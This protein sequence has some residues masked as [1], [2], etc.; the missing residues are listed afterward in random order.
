MRRKLK[1]LT[2]LLLTAALL[3]PSGSLAFAVE[4]GAG[5]P[6]APVTVYQETFQNGKGIAVQSGGPTLTVVQDKGF[7]GNED[8]YA[9]HVDNRKDNW[10]GVDLSY[11]DLGLKD[12]STYTVRITLFVD[13]GVTVPEEAKADVITAKETYTTFA[14]GLF[15]AGQPLSLNG[16]FTADS[17]SGD[18]AIRIQS[19]DIGKAVPFYIGEILITGE[20]AS[21]G[22]GI[23]RPPAMP[24]APVTFE[25]GLGGFTG[26][27]STET[28]TVT[29]EANHT[30]GGSFALKIE[31]RTN[32]WHGPN[33][34]LNPYIDQG[35]EYQ[36]SA[37][38]KLISPS[39]AQLQLST[40]V[41]DGNGAS[42]ISLQQK[43]IREEDGWVKLEGSYR[44]TNMSGNFATLYI[45][46]PNSADASFYID[47]VRFEPTG[48]GPIVIEEGLTPV[49][50]VYESDFLVGTAIS[51]EDLDGVRLQLMNK[52]FNAVTAGNAMKP[53][54]LQR[55]EDVFTFEAADAMVD[56]ALAEGHKVHGHVLVWHQ[57][58]PDWMNIGK[59]E[60]GNDVPLSREEA[61]DHLQKHI[62][63]VV[64]HFGDRVISWDVVNEAMNDNPANPEDWEN[65]LRRSPWFQAIGPD[66]VEQ[67]FLAAR[68]ALDDRQLNDVKLYYNDYNED[69]QNKATAIYHMVKEINE[70]Y[71]QEH[72]GTLLIDGLGM[73]GHYNLNTNPENVKLTLERFLSLGV[74]V[75]ITELDI[76]AG[77]NRQQ[78][79]KEAGSQAYLYAVLM[80]LFKNYAENIERVTFWGLDDGTSWRAENS[81]LPFD[82]RLQAKKAYYAI[83]D[84]EAYMEDYSP[85]SP[86]ALRGNA[87]YGT[88][89]LD[90]EADDLWSH[91]PELPINRFQSAWQGA[92]GSARVLWDED[93]LYVLVRV[94]DTQLD[95]TNEQEWQQDS[96]EIFVDENNGKTTFYQQDDGQYRVNFENERS[97]GGSTDPE[98]FLS[99]VKVSG[100]SYTL[101]AKI[102]FKTV[103]PAIDA[104]IGFDVQI[105]DAKDGSRQSVAAWNDTTGMGY[106]DPSVF[107]IVTLRDEGWTEP[108]PSPSPSPSP[109][110]T[111]TPG[112]TPSPSPNPN[113]NPGL[114]T[115]SNPGQPTGS[116]TPPA[117][118]ETAD[119]LV[120]L[121]PATT[122]VDGLSR[123]TV[124]AAELAQALQQA[125]APASGS[126]RIAVAVPPSEAGSYE[127]GIPAASLNGPQ[128]FEL[129]VRTEE[130]ALLLPAGLLADRKDTEGEVTVRIARVPA[131]QVPASLQRLNASVIRVELA[132]G[133]QAIGLK[134][135][136]VPATLYLP[137]KP[138]AAEARRTHT[139]VGFQLGAE[140]HPV[141]VI[142]SR[143][144]AA[145][146]AVSLQPSQWGLFAG[147]DGLKPYTDTGSV[148]WA[149]EAIEAMTARGLLDGTSTAASGRF[150]PSTPVTRGEFTALLVELLELK[151]SSGSAESFR[152]VPANAPYR[153]G[154]NIARELGIAGGYGDNSFRPEV[155]LSRQDMMSLTARALAAAGW[156]LTGDSLEGYADA[157]DLS[158]YARDSASALIGAG[159]VAGKAGKIAPAESLSRAEAAVI[160]HRIWSR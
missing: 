62:D 106:T 154:L 153:A 94:N 140:G 145:A 19:N 17:A 74:T 14:G 70:R 73:Q 47:D 148:S 72:P 63:T 48:T 147:A 39:S 99:A 71:A 49:K 16:T 24:F 79:E 133:G 135:A 144:D 151:P 82:S 59:D 64:K 108:E 28:L 65:A 83:I 111:P 33:I 57:Q 98:G 95:K 36:L 81:P 86:D 21:P 120:T 139:R 107:G 29:E 7:A 44:Y 45:E 53:D 138:S 30:E 50:D 35:Q 159:I 115:G 103:T 116:A 1:T 11:S 2:S 128:P 109:T 69:N 9:L 112:P 15:E 160:L 127:L 118:I 3:L 6:E 13:E 134:D 68:K 46:S 88:P 78:T 22:G 55:T 77:S 129:L 104:K 93:Y 43:N 125:A 4:A 84:P 96:V 119:G 121:K 58:S 117:A 20:P 155:A 123:S 37:W 75:S 150:E 100:T 87:L 143:Y 132:A 61:L 124:T 12:G 126:K 137:F 51:A 110:P 25:D 92:S 156:T 114:T 23:P 91:A 146:G 42:Y 54:A 102:P 158:P 38:V 66:Y 90:G 76:M 131:E 8:G 152:D 5:E 60:N 149:R 101:E 97:V 18:D 105:N 122:T 52:H 130:A 67:A 157:G 136:S 27:A 89:E 142:N 26:R 56:K 34:Q 141:P 32:N 113:P 85:V 31:G 41:G 40:Q 10:D 80:D